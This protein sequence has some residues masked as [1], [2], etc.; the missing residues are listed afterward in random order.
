MDRGKLFP[1]RRGWVRWCCFLNQPCNYQKVIIIQHFFKQFLYEW[2]SLGVWQILIKVYL[3][4]G[5][6]QWLLCVKVQ[7]K[8]CILNVHLIVNIKFTEMQIMLKSRINLQSY[9]KNILACL[10]NF[11]QFV[12]Y[13]YTQEPFLKRISL[14]KSWSI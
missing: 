7:M 12:M 5:L 13:Y 14:S 4:I 2:C 6:H 8:L 10:F 9:S 11:P 1:R 3:N